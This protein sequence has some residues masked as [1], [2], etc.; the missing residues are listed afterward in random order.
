MR[1]HR[2]LAAAAVGALTLAAGPAWGPSALG[3]DA[4]WQVVPSPGGRVSNL[5]SASFSAPDDG[6][7]VGSRGA[8]LT[9]A[10]IDPLVEHWDGG[11]WRVVPSPAVPSS[12][13]VLSGVSSSGPSDAWAV[14][15]QDPYGT[16]P[17]HALLM[18]W[19]GSTWATVEGPEGMGILS[20]VDARAADDVWAVGQN[21]FAHFDGST[22]SLVASPRP[23]ASPVAVTAIAADDVWAVGS[24]PAQRPGYRSPRPYTAHWDGAAWTSVRVPHPLGPGRLSSVSAAG[25]ND[26]WAVGGTG[27]LSASPYAVH[28]DGRAW[29]RVAVPNEGKG[30]QLSGVAVVAGG[31]VWAVGSRDDRLRNGFAVWRTLTEHWDGS[32]WTVVPSRNDSRHDNFLT[33]AVAS[34][35]RVWAV[36]GDGGTLVERR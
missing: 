2:S 34:G 24:R 23:D 7:A 35:G 28:F 10:G 27:S 8:S 21:V 1:S 36:G 30:N 4:G 31:D 22:W 15:W 11:R 33:A 26:V 19:D 20:A 16:T 3:A 6:W 25:P 32:A 18:H 17:V 29:H 5:S 9:S 14:G 12:D 13:E